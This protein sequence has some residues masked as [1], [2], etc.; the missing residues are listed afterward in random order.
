LAS[1]FLPWISFTTIYVN[2]YPEYSTEFTNI[3]VSSLAPF[4][5]D[6]VYHIRFFNNGTLETYDEELN[7][8]IPGVLAYG[9]IPLTVNMCTHFDS[10]YEVFNPVSMLSYFHL[11]SVCFVVV[12]LSTIKVW[13]ETSKWLTLTMVLLLI[14]STLSRLAVEIFG[15]HGSFHHYIYYLVYGGS[16]P[17][18]GLNLISNLLDSGFYFSL[19]SIIFV[20]LS[21]LH[22][23]SIDLPISL[24]ENQLGKV[25]S[26]L[27]FSERERPA[28]IF[29][30]ALLTSWLLGYFLFLIPI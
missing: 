14:T 22:P 13:N 21:Y 23:K 8:R 16:T 3:V 4:S 20:I 30:T 19:I 15:I 10:L 1:L 26:A 9:I 17:K 18:T 12:G 2:A 29:L 11:L 24:G 25:K 6:A 7:P 28:V 27:A 5:T